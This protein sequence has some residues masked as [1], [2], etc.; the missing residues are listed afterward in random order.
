[1]EPNENTSVIEETGSPLDSYQNYYKSLHAE[2]VTQ[3]FDE[4]VTNSQIDIEANR[5]TNK[6]IA[7]NNASTSSNDRAIRRQKTFRALSI[8]LLILS[9]IAIVWGIIEIT[10]YR[11][12]ILSCV[13][14]IVGAIGLIILSIWLIKKVKLKLNELNKTKDTLLGISRQLHAEAYTQMAALNKLLLKK[15]YNTEL[16]SKTLPLVDFDDTFDSRRLDYMQRKYALPDKHKK[17]FEQSTLFVQSGE[18]KGNPFFFRKDLMHDMGTKT[19]E[20]SLTIYWTT[21]ERDSE[22]KLR[23]VSHSETLH[24]EI[25][26]PYPYYTTSFELVYANEAAN[27][28]SFSRKPV[29][30]HLMSEKKLEKYVKKQSKDLRKLAEQSTKAGTNFT[31]MANEVFESLFRATDRDNESQY[32][33]LFTPLAQT[34]MTKLL[35]DDEAGFGDDFAFY[36]RKTINVVHPKHLDDARLIV[37]NNYFTGMDYDTVR[38]K[39]ND[40]HNEYFRHIFFTFAPI[41][42]IPLYIQHQTQEFIYQDLYDSNVSFYQHEMIVNSMDESAFTPVDSVTHNIL[43]TEL[44]TRQDD[45]DTINVYSWGYRGEERVEYVSKFGGDNRFHNVP[46]PWTEYFKVDKSTQV[47]VKLFNG[48]D[49]DEI[50]TDSG[51][52]KKGRLLARIRK[53]YY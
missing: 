19:Y 30:V 18:I 35:K 48:N 14:V 38:K 27:G 32:R 33:L 31:V 2:N 46:V 53:S 6:R 7:E 22:G 37:P 23:T 28:L 11:Q 47:D 20:G 25:E 21:T 43:K 40:Y 16:F 36:K 34:E 39:F 41:F 15:N 44:T 13:C 24:A 49:D 26:K 1:M 5:A 51:W 10:R 52:V 3:F 9:V 17:D 12:V 8:I 42:A 29:S 45:T 4:M 50:D